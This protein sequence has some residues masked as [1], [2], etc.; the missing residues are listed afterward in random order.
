[1]SSVTA[2]YASPTHTLNVANPANADD[3][4]QKASLDALHHAL[5]ATQSDLNVFLTARKLEEDRANGINVTSKGRK[6]E[7]EENEDGEVEDEE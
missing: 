4:S 1:M 6:D 7:D 3:G 2:S 5:L